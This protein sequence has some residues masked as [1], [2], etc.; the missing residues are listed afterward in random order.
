MIIESRLVHSHFVLAMMLEFLRFQYPHDY[1]TPKVRTDFPG[2]QALQALQDAG[3][4]YS[5]DAADR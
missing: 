3:A 1:K 5:V 2:P 4:A